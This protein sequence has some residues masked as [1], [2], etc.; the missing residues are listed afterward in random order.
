MSK[1]ILVRSPSELISKNL[2]GYGW[3]C[4]E[5]SSFS[6]FED[7]MKYVEGEQI[8]IGRQRNQISRFFHAKPGDIVVVPVHRAIVIGIVRGGKSY[9][10]NGGYGAN[11]INVDYFKNE[12]GEP[13]K[14]PRA[15][16]SQRLESRLKIRMTIASLN[17]FA[18]EI[19]GTSL[20]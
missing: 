6:N 16:L 5:M 10:E 13:I 2:A 3:D 20:S 9:D 19:E 7:L 12:H 1:I 14:I 4:I 15:K 11:R 8:N 18:D 17:E